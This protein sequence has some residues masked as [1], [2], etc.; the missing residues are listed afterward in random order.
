MLPQ[1]LAIIG[2]GND[3]A[4]YSLDKYEIEGSA[5][6]VAQK[7]GYG[8]PLHL[9]ALQLFPKAGAMAT[10]P[11]YILPVTK[12]EQ[13]TKAQGEILVTGTA[14]KAGSGTLAYTWD[15][16]KILHLLLK[17]CVADFPHFFNAFVL[18]ILQ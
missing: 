2:Q 12:E 1:Q 9:A 14:T 7:Y 6:A 8:S 11:V 10:F 15:F 13:W 4:V 17:L 16:L 5:D 3:D 18:V